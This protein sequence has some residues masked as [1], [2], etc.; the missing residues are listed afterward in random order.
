MLTFHPVQIERDLNRDDP[1]YVGH[2]FNLKGMWWTKRKQRQGLIISI[3]LGWYQLQKRQSWAPG[4]LSDEVFLTNLT[5]QVGDAR[6]ILEKFFTITRLGFN[7]GDGNKSP[8]IVSPRVLN[9]QMVEAIEAVINEVHFNPGVPPA[10]KTFIQTSVSI[11]PNRQS[12]IRSELIAK[13]RE[14]LLP[15]VSW[16]LK[17]K[18]ITFYYKPS[19]LLQAR[20]T[21]IWPIRAIEQ[22]PGWLRAELFGTVIDIE[23]AYCQFLVANLEK[24]YEG[25]LHLLEM[26][27]PDIIKADK[28]KKRFR[29]ELCRSV[30]RLEP[31]V[32]NI[33]VVKKLIMAL[34]N[35]SNATPAL[36]TNG[37]GRSEAVRIVR[38]AVPDML[39]TDLAAAGARLSA[40]TKQFKAAKRD[41]CIY[42]F[43]ALPSRENQKKIFRMYFDWEKK[44]RYEIW[45]AVGRTGLMLH[46]GVDGVITDMD[47]EELVYHIAR[48]TSIRVSVEKPE[49]E[50]ENESE[51]FAA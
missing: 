28:D 2:F 10:S 5:R 32:K 4:F 15:A 17:Q 37:S 16:L 14:D 21:S 43:K 30:L 20:D 47:E 1:L 42:F 51:S 45:N 11:R 38:E 19:G 48:K 39:S 33:G 29:E 27:Y 18:D 13:Q 8:T 23:N 6:V 31:T 24:K 9:R 50:N 7:F 49:Q 34:A 36:M 40:I 22:W 35:G 25:K 46:D 26:K 44:A 3:A 41:L 12:F